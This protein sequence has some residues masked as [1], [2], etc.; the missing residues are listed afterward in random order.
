MH[1]LH[2][3]AVE[4]EDKEDA[5]NIVEAALSENNYVEW[6]DWHVVGGG[7]WSDSQYENSYDMVISYVDEPIKFNETIYG[8]GT[9]SHR[10]DQDRSGGDADSGAGT[11]STVCTRYCY[12]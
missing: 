11:R 1:T 2:W 5:A 12:R 6:S 4:A 10:R 9:G 7:R 3:W 8:C